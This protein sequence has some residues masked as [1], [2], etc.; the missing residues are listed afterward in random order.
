MGRKFKDGK[1]SGKYKV[2]MK[3]VF[4]FIIY[5]IIQISSFDSHQNIFKKVH[6][7]MKINYNEMISI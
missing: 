4:F 7:V 2:L 6:I 1:S 5:I 3:I